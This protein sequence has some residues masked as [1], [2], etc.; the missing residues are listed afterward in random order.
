MKKYML[1]ITAAVCILAVIGMICALTIKRPASNGFTPPAFDTS[2]QSGT[3]T[4]AEDM[5][6]SELD[7]K[8][9]KVSVCG[10]LTAKG[11]KVDLYLTSPEENTVWLKVRLLDENDSILGETGLVKPGEYVRSLTLG[12][13]PKQS[14]TVKIKIMSYEPDTY[15][16][17]GTASLNTT[18]TVR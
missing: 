7:A 16:S 15:Y 4:V 18:L 13:M 9:F 11:G 2:A 10:K 12:A 1:P 17:A 14:E 3:P 5:G 6:Y 8:A